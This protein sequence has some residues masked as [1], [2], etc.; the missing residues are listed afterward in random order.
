VGVPRD[1]IVALVR[2][3]DVVEADGIYF[4]TSAV[5]ELAS[6]VSAALERTPDGLTMA[7]LRDVAGTTRKYALA[8]ATVLDRHGL[9]IRRG[10]VRLAGPRLASGSVQRDVT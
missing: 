2:R 6:R 1:E 10:D 8:L 7:A 5:D 4:A 3:G 9:T